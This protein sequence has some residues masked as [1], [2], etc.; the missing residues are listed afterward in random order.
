MKKGFVG[1]IVQARLGSTRL[2]GKVLCEISGKPLI[3]HIIKRISSTKLVEK[4]ILATTTNPLD[5]ELENWAKEN[6][7]ECFRGEEINVLNRFYECAKI[8]SLDTIVRVTAD[9]PLKDASIIDETIQYFIEQDL[10]FASNNNPPTY[11]EGLDVEVF[12]MEALALAKFSNTTSFEQEHVTQFFHKR[13]EQ[14]RIGNLEYIKDL[15]NL[16]W[17]VDT[18][19]D[20]KMVRIIYSHLFDKNNLFSFQDVLNLLEKFPEILNINMN[21]NR[22]TMYQKK[23]I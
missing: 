10:D 22:S 17:T 8:Y 9:D 12:S 3:W 5:D 6:N 1:A 18:A 2:P 20:L 21:E 13:Q 4:V 15:S 14:F 19:K 23:K 16:R 7:V 11:P